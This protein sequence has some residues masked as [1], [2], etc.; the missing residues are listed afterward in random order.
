MANE[1][2]WYPDPRTPETRVRYWDGEGWTE[3]VEVNPSLFTDALDG[4]SDHVDEDS[5]LDG[6]QFEFRQHKTIPLTRL[7]KMERAA[8]NAQSALLFQF[9]AILILVSAST[10]FALMEN[11]ETTNGLS[12]VREATSS[13]SILSVAL[14][15]IFGVSIAAI[16]TAFVL[17]LRWQGMSA[18]FSRDLG[19]TA[20]FSPTIGIVWW[21]VPFANLWLPWMAMLDMLPVLHSVR[22]NVKQWL[23]AALAPTIYGTVGY[24]ILVGLMYLMSDMLTSGNSLPIVF[25]QILFYIVAAAGL[26]TGIIVVAIP[27]FARKSVGGIM[28]YQISEYER[29]TRGSSRS[30]DAS[31]GSERRL[32]AYGKLM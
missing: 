27:L 16:V 13:V 18:A 7:G 26:A 28:D 24:A 17:Q 15:L 12:R 22:K 4:I 2:G 30:G 14:L 9:S 6:R 5:E 32:S 20:R 21:F 8:S 3:K 29:Q 31:M 1:A 25:V 11:S 19:L 23:L 10:V